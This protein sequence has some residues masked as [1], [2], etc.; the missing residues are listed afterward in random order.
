MVYD[1]K[2]LEPLHKLT[3]SGAETYSKILELRADE[4]LFKSKHPI[5]YWWQRI[6]NFLIEGDLSWPGT[7]Y[8]DD[9]EYRDGFSYG[10]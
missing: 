2:T 1:N 6:A 8:R 10:C 3:T 5:I 9:E 7:G 4:M